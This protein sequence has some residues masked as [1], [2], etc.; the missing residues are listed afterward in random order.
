MLPT[1]SSSGESGL[2]SPRSCCRLK[3]TCRHTSADTS[4]LQ[5][6]SAWRW[7]PTLIYT[8]MNVC[9]YYIY[10]Y[11]YACMCV[12]MYVCMYAG[13]FGTLQEHAIPIELAL[14]TKRLSHIQKCRT[15]ACSGSRLV[16]PASCI[17][18]WRARHRYRQNAP[19]A[20]RFFSLSLSLSLILLLSL[21]PSLSPS[22]CQILPATGSYCML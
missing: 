9:V 4:D 3:S 13:I 5:N 20:L 22:L 2:G 21:S 16:S 12:C 6:A 11:I 19:R 14:C 7:F 1:S 10:V 18:C 17:T 8:C 15:N